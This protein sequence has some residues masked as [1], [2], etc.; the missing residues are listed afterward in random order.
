[1]SIKS[2]LIQ[3]SESDLSSVQVIISFAKIKNG[4][5]QSSEI[6]SWCYGVVLTRGPI[7]QAT[8]RSSRAE[9]IWSGGKIQIGTGKAATSLSKR[10][11][12]ATSTNSNSLLSFLHCPWTLSIGCSKVTTCKWH[13]AKISNGSWGTRCLTQ[14]FLINCSQENSIGNKPF[15]NLAAVYQ[16]FFGGES[17]HMLGV[18]L[19]D[20][21]PN[22][23][24][25]F[26]HILE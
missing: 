25:S 13:L 16:T 4:T 11:L 12:A 15:R 10:F 7:Y 23:R 19:A 17:I 20:L 14:H 3:C 21:H 5:V 9:F 18:E 2:E 24:V 6:R 22:K 26:K 1:M 8:S